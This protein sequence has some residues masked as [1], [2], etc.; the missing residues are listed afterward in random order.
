M[1]QKMLVTAL[2]TVLFTTASFSQINLNNLYSRYVR[3]GT[4]LTTR[5]DTV[6]MKTV[7]SSGNSLM[8]LTIAYTP[9]PYNNGSIVVK[10][11]LIAKATFDSIETT[12][13]F[14]LPADFAVDSMWLWIDGKR[15]EA[16]IQD[17]AL[18]ASQYQ[19]IVG[20]RKDPALLQYSGNGYYNLSIFPAFLNTTRKI[21]LQFHYTFDDAAAGKISAAHPVRYDSTYNSRIVPVVK[22]SFSSLDNAEYTVNYPGVGSGTFSKSSKLVLSSNNVVRFGPGLI[23]SDDPSEANEFLWIAQDNIREKVSA[24][25]NVQIADTNVLFEKEPDTR[26]IA[27]DLRNKMWNWNDYYKDRAEYL[28]QKYST[29]SYYKDIDILNRM[30]KYI[31]LCLEHYLKSDQKFN[32][33]FG[34]ATVST[35]FDKPVPVH[36]EYIKEAIEAVLKFTP[37]NKS[38]TEMVVAEAVKQASSG[39]IILVSDLFEPYNYYTYEKSIYTITENGKLY[40]ETFDRI[41][42]LADSSGATIFTIDDNSRLSQ[43]SYAS[44]G[45]RLGS[46]L[47]FYN[48]EYRY[49]IVDGRRIKIPMMP[50]LFGS[51]NTSGIRSIKITSDKLEDIV[52]TT[53]GYSYVWNPRSDLMVDAMV[54]PYYYTYNQTSAQVYIAGESGAA[55]DGKVTFTVQGKLSGLKF[56]KTF[57]AVGLNSVAGDPGTVQW[58]FRN[59]EQMAAVNYTKFAADIK[60][61]GVQY[62]LITRQ[63]SLLALEPGIEMWKDTVYTP[64]DVATVD[65]LPTTARTTTEMSDM[66]YSKTNGALTTA[67]GTGIDIDGISLLDLISHNGISDVITPS[68]I[69]NSKAKRFSALYQNG[70]IRISN[71]SITGRV[72]LQLFDLK[73]RVVVEKVL[74]EKDFTNSTYNWSLG[75]KSANLSSGYYMLHISSS[76]KRIAVRMP[77]SCMQ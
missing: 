16:K 18:A 37:D 28:G 7:V 43:V 69:A 66:N 60:N 52:Y 77:I 24:G 32:I 68:P 10:D 49:E 76:G 62:H 48:I 46:L 30:Q 72:T 2:S 45:F 39:V 75:M 65:A 51:R 25:I 59:A 41:L 11:T 19:Q 55:L 70:T 1:I 67:S 6:D 23:S 58:A 38:S 21:E 42:S 63:T 35:L 36:P 56:S 27:I 22:A 71:A 73:G 50:P 53:D 12:T 26:I 4:S 47:N 33:V 5:I 14:R 15:V 64:K 3:G 34:G 29:N 57:V 61:I 40:N 44:G 13:S 31:L 17:R 8:N 74:S 20:T 54:E 9:V